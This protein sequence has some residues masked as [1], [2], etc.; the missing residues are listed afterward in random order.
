MKTKTSQSSPLGINQ[1]VPPSAG[2]DGWVAITLA[3]GKKTMGANSYWDRD[4]DLDLDRL[5]TLGATTL[6]PLI[7]DAELTYLKIPTLVDSAEKRGLAVRRF[8]FHDG[9]IPTDRRETV[10]FVQE[11][12]ARFRAGERIVMHCNGGLGRAGTMAACL[13]LALGLDHTAEQAIRS[14]RKA[15]GPR[16]IETR[17][18]EAFIA[19]FISS[20]SVRGRD[21]AAR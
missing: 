14:V 11:L 6:V 16:A 1:V 4:L 21:S 3:P 2:T 13:R 19:E 20:W 5:V 17:E 8:P 9:G 18:Q 15:R 12:I 7:E 10:R